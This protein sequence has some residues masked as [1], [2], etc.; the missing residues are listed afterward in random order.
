VKLYADAKVGSQ[1]N[2]VYCYGA[3]GGAELFGNV[4]A[5]TVFGYPL[6]KHYTLW[7]KDVSAS[8]VANYVPAD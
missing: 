1:T 8:L 5:P 2:F 6:S 3:D 7:T 4:E